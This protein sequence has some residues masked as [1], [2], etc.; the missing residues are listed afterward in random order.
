VRGVT[1][2]SKLLQPDSP[3][4]IG[5][6]NATESTTRGTDGY[7]DRPAQAGAG[8]RDRAIP[9]SRNPHART[10]PIGDQLPLPDP[11]RRA[12]TGARA[13]PSDHR[14]PGPARSLR[15]GYGGPRAPGI[16]AARRREHLSPPGAT[17]MPV[18]AFR[19]CRHPRSRGIAS[20]R[21]RERTSRS[22][23]PRCPRSP[24]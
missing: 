2:D 22:L 20:S 14:R 6:S 9:R 21:C 4:V 5:Y 11:H 17:G 19:Q 7:H 15:P 3:P 13:Q 1:T 18:A 16:P 23:S 8:P 12:R 24:R 10:A